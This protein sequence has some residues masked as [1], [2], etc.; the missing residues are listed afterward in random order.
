MLN[1]E[2]KNPKSLL[3]GRKIGFLAGLL[4]F[5]SMLTF[6]LS[7]FKVIFVGWGAYFTIIAFVILIYILVLIIKN[8]MKKKRTV[9]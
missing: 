1:F 9:E 7:R 6:I 4:I 3:V 8:K 5:V 2:K